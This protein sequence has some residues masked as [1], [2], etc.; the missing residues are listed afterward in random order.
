MGRVVA[1][2]TRKE[3]KSSAFGLEQLLLRAEQMT[4]K[5]GWYL[6]ETVQC[7]LGKKKKKFVI[8]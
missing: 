4:T 2:F 5:Q 7:H 1:C 3:A 8:E 6:L